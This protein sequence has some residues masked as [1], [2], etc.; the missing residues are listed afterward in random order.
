MAVEV[1]KLDLEGE[2]CPYTL[3]S[4][5]KKIEEIG[6]DLKAGLKI[7]EITV[8]HPPVIDNFPEEFERRGHKVKVVKYSLS[9]WRVIVQN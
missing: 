9:R 8:D 4:A 1:V 6:A 5:I 3:I 2:I 7:L